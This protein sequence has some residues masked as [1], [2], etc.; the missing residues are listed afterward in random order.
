M[1][2]WTIIIVAL[3]LG[4]LTG[5]AI[6]KAIGV[7]NAS[8]SSGG[9]ATV[10][11]GGF[12]ALNGSASAP[13]WSLPLLANPAQ[14]ISLAQFRGRDVVINFWASWCIPCQSEM[15]AMEHVS[16]LAG[17]QVTFIGVNTADQ[18]ASAL[19]F[20]AKTKV[21]YPVAFDPLSVVGSQY[22][23]LGLPVTVFISKSGKMIG[24]DVGAM[25]QATLEQLIDKE[26]HITLGK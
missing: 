18:A 11:T 22:G 3:A 17:S 12:S 6:T 20:V 8:S 24:R 9:H 7:S 14:K 10:L 13:Q 2:R 23:V 16:S 4:S 15:P 19:A 25:T 5:L 26:F 21:T 1:R